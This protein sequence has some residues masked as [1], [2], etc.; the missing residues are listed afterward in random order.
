MTMRSKMAVLAVVGTTLVVAADAF[1]A[2]AANGERLAR[3]WCASCHI[4]A[5]DQ[6]RGASTQAAPFSTVA[7]KS[8]FDQNKLAFFLLA[9]HPKMPDMS[10][11]RAEASDLAAYIMRQKSAK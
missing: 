3:R 10:L 11:S 5:A 6:Q 4:V 9:P 8:G 2:D 7:D 1:A